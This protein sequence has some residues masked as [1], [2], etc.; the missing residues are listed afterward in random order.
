MMTLNLKTFGRGNESIRKESEIQH[1]NTDHN[2]KGMKPERDGIP[3]VTKKNLK[4]TNICPIFECAIDSIQMLDNVPNEEK[5]N[6]IV[7]L[8]AHL[9]TTN[10]QL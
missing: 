1:N 6:P 5:K 3:N 2:E 4:N 10:N 7:T 9:S 8:S